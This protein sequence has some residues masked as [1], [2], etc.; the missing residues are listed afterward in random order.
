[1][2]DFDRVEE[3]NLKR[4]NFYPED[5][6]K[7]KSIALAERLSEK[8]DRPVSYCTLSIEYVRISKNALVVSCV[9]NGI[10]RAAIEKG[11]DYKYRWWIDAGNGDNY[12]Q[13][14]IGNSKVAIFN[15]K[16][17]IISQLP[18]PS[19][20]R[21][22]ILQ[23]APPQP[24]CAEV[25][26]QGPTINQTMAALTLEVIRRLINGNCPWLQI[27]VDMEHAAM[28]RVFAL[29]DSCQKI[30]HTKNKKIIQIIEE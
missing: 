24:D 15:K 7:Y 8:F 11:A 16:T 2:V 26:T 6:G 18:F 17:G 21:P 10:A 23:Q 19:L 13:V 20:Q 25:D 1:M 29:P 28:T 5:I 30:L 27:M 4:Q 3:K 14:L 9:D 12:G 22:E